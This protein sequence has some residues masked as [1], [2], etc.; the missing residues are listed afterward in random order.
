M[1]RLLIVLLVLLT[2]ATLIAK[3][4]EGAGTAGDKAFGQTIGSS[5]IEVQPILIGGSDSTKTVII[6]PFAGAWDFYLKVILV[7]GGALM[8]LRF[9]LE[10]VSAVIFES[11]VDNIS[12]IRQVLVRFIVVISIVC[13]SYALIGLVF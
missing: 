8:L 11:D 1:R 3:E 7:V 13:F 4:P 12:K 5:N 6:N 10:L 9:A 2:A